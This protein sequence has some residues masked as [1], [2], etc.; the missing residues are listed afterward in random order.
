[1]PA[2]FA[3]TGTIEAGDQWWHAFESPGLNRAVEVA[4][5]DNFDLLATWDRLAQ[6][7]AIARREG[8][9]LYPRIDGQAEAARSRGASGN[10]T[11]AFSVG[12]V[13]GYEVDLWG[14]VR[15]LTRAALIDVD[16][17]AADVQT[18]ALTLAAAVVETWNRLGA[19]DEEIRLLQAQIETNRQV[20]ELV[21]ERFRQGVVQAADVLRQ[22]QLVE[23]T[24]G[25]LRL[26]EQRRDVLRHQLAVLMGRP[27]RSELSALGFRIEDATLAMPGELPRTGVPSEVLQ[28][29][30]DVRSA[31]LGV[32]AQDE[33]VWAAVAARYPR[34]SLAATVS[35]G[36]PRIEDV[37]R[38][39]AASIAAGLTAPVFDGGELR[40]EADRN[41]ALLSE[42]VR[43]YG[44]AVL[45][46]LQE[47]EDA[48]VS[49]ISQ[50]AYLA[51]L[52]RQLELAAGVIDRTRAS[53][54]NGQ[55][56]YLRVLDALT[57]R[58]SLERTYLDARLELMLQ[59]IRLHRAIAGPLEL[60]RPALA[61][62]RRD[63]A[64]TEPAAN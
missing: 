18:A 20:L 27:P 12:L 23:Q 50:R 56:D 48:I 58:Q 40:A 21:T 53:Y 42:R 31:E 10:Y 15:S 37:F 64:D 6:A 1:M 16:A 39:F 54:L 45:R 19:A 2:S 55:L 38:D 14:R 30:P 29:R 13:A 9:E 47:V 35:T 59:R 46:A 62:I 57:S 49:E 33:R 5:T 32:I 60:E 24:E 34:L 11:N 3:A 51:S 17:S 41:R 22:R 63:A 43:A 25:L 7:E 61:G 52:E 36:G 44:A 26:A 4:L 8:A 28:R